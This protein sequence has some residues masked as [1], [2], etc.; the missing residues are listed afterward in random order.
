MIMEE[1]N[2]KQARLVSLLD[3]GKFMEKLGKSISRGEII[4]W[5]IILNRSIDVDFH[6]IL[7]S[8]VK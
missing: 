2:A 3:L 7:G 8:Q 6:Y 1:I 5:G 4:G